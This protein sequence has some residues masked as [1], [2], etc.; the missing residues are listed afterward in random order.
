[1]EEEKIGLIIN[2]I[3]VDE[4][5]EIMEKVREIEQRDTSRVIFTQIKGLEHKPVEEAAEVVKK[6]FPTIKVKKNE[7]HS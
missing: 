6:V 1:M 4:A 5:R 7:H 2:H 3:T